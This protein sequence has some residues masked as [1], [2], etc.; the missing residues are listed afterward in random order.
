[1]HSTF[2]I[3]VVGALAGTITVYTTMPLDVVKTRLQS[4]GAKGSIWSNLIHVVK[5]D[6]VGALWKGATPRLSRLV[7]SGG[8]V[9][10]IFESV[11]SIYNSFS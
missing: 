5:E 11:I 7:V 2:V 6:G 8:I 4:I 9:F 1:M 10:T 3:L